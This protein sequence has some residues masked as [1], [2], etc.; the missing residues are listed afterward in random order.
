ML[1]SKSKTRQETQPRQSRRSWQREAKRLSLQFIRLR[2]SLHPIIL[3]RSTSL[4]ARVRSSKSGWEV[5][6]P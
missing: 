3:R 5:R 4:N 1:R 6:Q 2:R